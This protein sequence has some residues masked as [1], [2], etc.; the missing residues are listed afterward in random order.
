MLEQRKVNV[1]VT[2]DIPNWEF[3]QLLAAPLN[4][5]HVIE[6][7]WQS[8]LADSDCEVDFIVVAQA[9]RGSFAEADIERLCR[10][11]PLAQKVL[12]IASWCEGETRSGEPLFGLHRVYIRDW[13]QAFARMRD[14]YSVKGTTRLSRPVTESRSDYLYAI[15]QIPHAS[16]PLNIAAQTV[17]PDCFETLTEFCKL[18]NWTLQRLE[19]CTKCDLVVVE[20]YRSIEETQRSKPMIQSLGNVPVVVICGF[21]RAQDN[22]YLDAHFTAVHLLGK[23]FDNGMLENAILQLASQGKLKLVIDVA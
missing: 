12:V 23:P 21:P 6:R 16:G 20:C 18:R 15:P 2:G 14:A 5:C 22:E 19:A 7:D 10:Q 9:R 17:S 4:D 3:K 13:A 1:L 8:V 11:F